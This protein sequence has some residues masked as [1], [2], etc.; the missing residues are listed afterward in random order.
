[1]TETKQLRVRCQICGMT[2]AIVD[3]SALHLPIRGGMFLSPD[4]AHGI[5]PPFHP[6][7]IEHFFC[8]YGKHLFQWNP[9]E[10]MTNEGI[11]SLRE[12]MILARGP[13]ASARESE[14]AIGR[15]VRIDMGL[16]DPDPEPEP[17]EPEEETGEA[18]FECPECG[19]SFSTPRKLGA[20]RFAKHGVRGRS[21]A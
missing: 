14:E 17:E 12:K 7:Q 16:L 8:P 13:E 5:P 3:P 21:K 20:H 19:E 10:I 15:R 4:P 11:F 2:I 1:M 9:D 6:E 18:L